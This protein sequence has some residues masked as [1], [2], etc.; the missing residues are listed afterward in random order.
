MVVKQSLEEVEPKDD[1]KP[2]ELN[3]TESAKLSHT[4]KLPQNHTKEMASFSGL[5]VTQSLSSAKDSKEP[6]DS[7][8]DKTKTT[9]KQF[10]QNNMTER[11]KYQTTEKHIRKL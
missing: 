4:D 3:N 1:V 9:E 7:A 10:P 2:D 8:K 6:G 11:H 5:T